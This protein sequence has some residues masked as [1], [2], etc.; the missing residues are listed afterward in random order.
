MLVHICCSVDS[1]YFLQQLQKDF[2]NEE[3][4]GFFYN[5]NIHPFSEYYL[6]LYDVKYSCKKLGIKLIEGE[7]DFENWLKVA[8]GLENEP[9]KG[10]RCTVCFDRRLEITAKKALELGCK[11]FTTT[12]LM[13]PLKS[14]EKLKI[15]GNN[16]SKKYNLNFV[17]KDYRISQGMHLQAFEVKQNKIYRQNYCGCM[18]ALKSQRETQDKFCDELISPI[19]QQIL[20]ESIESRIELY[21]RRNYLEE[22]KQEYKVIKQRFLN[23]R[24]LNAK[25]IYEKKVIPS[26]FVCYSTLQNKKTQGKIEYCKNDINYL[27]KNEVKIVSLSVFNKLNLTNYKSIKQLIWSPLKFEDEL[28]F[29]NNIL[30]NPYDLSA[31]I[32]LD[33]ILNKKI[34]ILCDSEIYEDVKEEIV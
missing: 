32:V 16:L 8:R 1:H 5:P 30:N 22:S 24:L 28:I 19:G 25:V 18:Y 17:F 14:Q 34:E 2:P 31:L 33:T 27:N 12:L 9:E 10:N 6:R 15:I 21:K 7:Y 20:P 4:V 26:Y 13:S 3:I 23:Y 11:S 29:R